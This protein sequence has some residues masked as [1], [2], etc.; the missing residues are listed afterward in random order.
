MKFQAIHHIT[1]KLVAEGNSYKEC[2]DKAFAAMPFKDGEVAPYYIV[3]D[4]G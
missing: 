4:R 1:R 3:F 2:S